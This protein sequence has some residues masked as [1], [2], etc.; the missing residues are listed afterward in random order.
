M[1]RKRFFALITGFALVAT[2]AAPLTSFGMT[3][4]EMQQMIAQLNQQIQQLQ[5][6]LAALG[7][8]PAVP[9]FTGIPANFTFDRNL[10][11]GS[12]GDDVKYL[13]IVLNADPA[14]RLRESGVGAPGQETSYFGPLTETAVIKFQEKYA[15]EVLTP[16][17]I[18]S[19][20]GFVGTTTRAK[21]NAMLVEATE[22]DL[23]PPPPIDDDDED[24]EEEEEVPVAGLNV[25][26][27]P[28]SP[29][30]TILIAGQS[31]A[32]LA[33]FI[34]S[35]NATVK[36]VTFQRTGI[37]A[38]TTLG[39]VYLF[40]G[41][42]RLTSAASITADGTVTFSATELFKVEGVKVLSVRADIATGTAGQTV[43]IRL[44]NVTVSDGDVAGT[45]IAGANHSIAAA[46][47]ATVTITAAASLPSA[48]TLDPAEDVT[49]WQD[50]LNITTRSVT[51]S[52]FTLRKL[53]SAD[54]DALVNLE[55]YVDGSKVASADSLD[56]E[57]YAVFHFA[58]P[59][60]L[61]VGNRVVMVKADIVGGSGRTIQM[62][63]QN[64]ADI[65]L[66]D[67]NFNARVALVDSGATTYTV[68]NGTAGILNINSGVLTVAKATDSPAG[69][70]TKD[71]NS[72]TLAKFDLTANGE[73][74]RVETLAVQIQ[75]TGGTIVDLRNGMVRVNG[76]QVGSLTKLTHNV[77]STFTTN[78]TV[79]PGS[80]AVLEIVADIVADG[81]TAVAEGDTFYVR[82]PDDTGLAYGVNSNETVTVPS[83]NKDGNT[84]TVAVG[85]ITLARQSTYT[86]RNIVV[87]QNNYKIAAYNLYGNVTE[88]VN[89][90]TV[91]ADIAFSGG[92]TWAVDQLRNVYLKYGDT[93][94]ATKATV[95]SPAVWNV[96]FTLPKNSVMPIEI[97]AD[98]L[99]G[100][101]A[102]DT[103]TLT[104]TVT[105]IT[106]L[107]AETKG[108]TGIGGQVLT[109][110]AGA[111][112]VA[113]AADSPVAS[114][115]HGSQTVTAAKYD[116]TAEN[117]SFDITR[118]RV[119]VSSATTVANVH[120][121]DGTSVIA[122]MPGGT[123]ITFPGL[124]IN[125]PANGTKS[126]SVQLE[127]GSIGAGAGTTGANNTVTLTSYRYR[128]SSTGVESGD[129]TVNL[130][131]NALYTYK[132]VPTITTVALP[133]TILSN[134]VRTLA[135]F[136]VAA[137]GDSIGWKKLLFDVTKTQAI[138]VASPVLYD[139][140]A[141]ANVDGTAIAANLGAST[142][143]SG[144]ITFIADNEQLVS[145]PR[146]YEL[147]GTISA[148][149]SAGQYVSTKISRPTT[150]FT[151]SNAA[152][153]TN[154]A[155]GYIY[156]DADNDQEVTTDDI[157]WNATS[158]YTAADVEASA[159]VA[160]HDAGGKIREAYGIGGNITLTLN[161][162][163]AD[164]VTI[165]AATF[166]V[167][168]AG[169]GDLVCTPFTNTNGTGAV[170]V[171]TTEFGG[172]KSVVCKGAASDTQLK[173][174]GLTV[175]NPTNQSTGN[176]NV[177]TIAITKEADYALGS[178]VATD[179]SDLG[180]VLSES[181][182]HSA[183]F[184]WTD[185]SASAHSVTTTDWT[186]DFRV[187]ELPLTDQTLN[188]AS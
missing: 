28:D 73:P 182:V 17:G 163:A 75:N 97:Y 4:E 62:S 101:T 72:V 68:A 156:A 147:R 6:Q 53:G 15:N 50:T 183:S 29:A 57:G 123:D 104:T 11:L 161:S 5:A 36:S 78:F 136:T 169:A 26:L 116:F 141:G 125:V 188:Y 7:E 106:A 160:G 154:A 174:L 115:V 70:I 8:T 32:E 143:T 142:A 16:F 25:S 45:P 76:A 179:N 44:T 71:A 173:L 30:A 168:G 117:E 187:N 98:V 87:P 80:P 102:N 64:R 157:R 47:L 74:V 49:V 12:S 139:V 48:T 152:L 107:S 111:I 150:T 118:M 109:A 59:A 2:L 27:A 86:D 155:S 19:G 137:N 148:A 54:N 127:L 58:T 178:T 88:D 103:L 99:T 22:P 10:R 85:A 20:T 51:L 164:A 162:S 159:D 40:D 46:T 95:T 172:I 185:R 146:T 81:S 9:A 79:T 56:S 42:K 124:S 184:V 91:S 176:V 1:N 69:N 13:Q 96:S 113:L 181:V 112:N 140:T 170:T 151:A 134:G 67:S 128:P 110:K 131:G 121:H 94:A 130:A 21:L 132:A 105:G 39:N 23:P 33:K 158:R 90:H 120:L 89:I 126:I 129:T 138:G 84:L 145:V 186:D 77:N 35:G 122:T 166:T 165:G 3:V 171:G 34:F 153:A 149:G 63:L 100:A 133:S 108:T 37:S 180:L 14:T 144:T 119:G 66:I 167:T 24:E 135:K 55:L 114:I 177:M 43:G 82:L 38:N 61:N 175:T 18:T 31:T 65:G 93:V 52:S 41:A 83:G 92:A 60:T